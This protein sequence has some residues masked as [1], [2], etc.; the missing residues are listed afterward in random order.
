METQTYKESTPA[1]VRTQLL[2]TAIAVCG[3]F[4]VVSL[5]DVLFP[6]SMTA[7]CAYMLEKYPLENFSFIDKSAREETLTCL[8]LQWRYRQKSWKINPQYIDR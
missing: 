4:G 5:W 1:P 8:H 3:L 6:P 2:V 7:H